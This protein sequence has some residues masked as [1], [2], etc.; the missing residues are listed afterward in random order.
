MHTTTRPTLSKEAASL[1]YRAL[2]VQK[3]LTWC[4]QIVFGLD[5]LLR[6]NQLLT[7][8]PFKAEVHKFRGPSCRGD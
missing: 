3:Y 8:V 2:Y 1:T 7:D 5:L 6:N 4:D